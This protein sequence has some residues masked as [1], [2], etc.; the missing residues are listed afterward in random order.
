MGRIIFTAIVSVILFSTI[1]AGNQQAYAPAILVDDFDQGGGTFTSGAGPTPSILVFSDSSVGPSSLNRDVFLEVMSGPPMQVDLDITPSL[2]EIIPA[3]NDYILKVKYFTGAPIDIFGA[4]AYEVQFDQN[5][6]P[7]ATLSLEIQ[8]LSLVSC[9]PIPIPLGFVLVSI[10]IDELNCP[11][12]SSINL[13]QVTSV[14]FVV[15]STATTGSTSIGSSS[16]IIID[17]G[18]PVGG[19]SIPID[20]TALLVAGFNANS[21]WMIPTVLGMAGAG[22]AIFKL[23]RI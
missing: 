3:V 17:D 10:P 23:K 1:F 11:G 16:L 4:T 12:I 22:I 18:V 8:E 19:T 13:T 7:T 14:T 2:L 15:Y 20:T 6:N 9:N 21:I 5:F